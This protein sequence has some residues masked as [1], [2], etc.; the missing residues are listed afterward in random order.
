MTSKKTGHPRI[1][2]PAKRTRSHTGGRQVQAPD[3]LRDLVKRAKVRKLTP[4]AVP[5]I[6]DCDV[7]AIP[8]TA[9]YKIFGDTYICS[10]HLDQLTA[11]LG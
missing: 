1:V 10:K 9:H 5:W 7:C 3:F 4:E 6:Y 2:K 8:N 11:R